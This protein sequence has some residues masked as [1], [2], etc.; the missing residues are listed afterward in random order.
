MKFSHP[1]ARA[2]KLWSAKSLDGTDQP[3]LI[4]VTT[5]ELDAGRKNYKEKLINKLSTAARE[6]LAET[7]EATAFVLTNRA[8]D[9]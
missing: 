9:W 8:R 7:R 3:L 1:L 5:I 4:I 2:A 6:Y